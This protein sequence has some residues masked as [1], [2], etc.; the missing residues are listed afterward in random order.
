MQKGYCPGSAGAAEAPR[1]IV[2]IRAEASD[3]SAAESSFQSRSRA[4][5]GG[6]RTPHVTAWKLAVRKLL[7]KLRRQL[8][9]GILLVQMRLRV[10]PAVVTVVGRLIRV[11]LSTPIVRGRFHRVGTRSAFPFLCPSLPQP[12]DDLLQALD[13][14]F[15][16][17]TFLIVA[18]RLNAN[19]L[20][21]QQR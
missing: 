10:L 12:F 14:L 1:R 18:H 13:C 6:L 2:L 3:A 16:F 7:R 19:R 15:G 17:G 4:V 20:A 9:H 11:K 8:R 5:R 21:S